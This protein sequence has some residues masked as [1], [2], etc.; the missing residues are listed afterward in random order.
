MLTRYYPKNYH[1]HHKINCIT[2][3]CN[4]CLPTKNLM[5]YIVF[6]RN[7]NVVAIT[8]VESTPAVQDANSLLKC[9]HLS[10]VLKLIPSSLAI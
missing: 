7:D 9:F 4:G 5:L 3:I 10:D 1:M 8:H 6:L 2:E